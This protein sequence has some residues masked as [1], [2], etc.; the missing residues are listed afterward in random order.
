MA[1]PQ[2]TNDPRGL[3][4]VAQGQIF[5]QESNY[6]EL[7]RNDRQYEVRAERAEDYFPNSGTIW[8]HIW[9]RYITFKSYVRKLFSKRK[10]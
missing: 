9:D 6:W 8:T 10:Q 3:T 1:Q 7:N 2:E 5:P 4:M